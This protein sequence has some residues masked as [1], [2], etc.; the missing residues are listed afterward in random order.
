[1]NKHDRMAEAEHKAWAA[2]MKARGEKLLA[3]EERE[4]HKLSLQARFDKG[5]ITDRDERDFWITFYQYQ[6]AAFAEHFGPKYTPET[7][8]DSDRAN[9]G[10]ADWT[11]LV[12]A[13]RHI[14]SYLEQHD[15]DHEAAGL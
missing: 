6:V 11:A 2:R 10:R 5:L 12:N 15:S 9:V 7:W 1:M 8:E 13:V 14:Q 4:W 3:R